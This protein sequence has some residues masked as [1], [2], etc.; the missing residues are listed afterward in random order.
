MRGGPTSTTTLATFEMTKASVGNLHTT[1]PPFVHDYSVT[2]NHAKTAGNLLLLR[3]RFI[4][5]KSS[6]LLESKEPR[7]YPVEFDGPSRDTDAFEIALPP[8]LR[9]G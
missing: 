3:P 1:D 5:N 8:R 4:G 2:R 6:D 9:S 7:K